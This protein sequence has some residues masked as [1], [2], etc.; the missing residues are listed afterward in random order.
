MRERI[1]DLRATERHSPN[2]DYVVDPPDELRIEFLADEDRYLNRDVTVRQDGCIT[3]L[4]LDDVQVDG[5][6]PMSIA[7]KLEERYSEFIKEPRILVT[8]TAYRSKRIF[9]TGEVGRQGSIP[10]TGQQTVA[11]ALGEV[12]GLTRRAWLAHAKVIRGDV[13]DPEIYAIDLNELLFAGDM[14]QNIM[15][16][17]DDHLRVPPNPFAW[18]GYQLDN[19]LYPFR[20]ILSTFST[21]EGLTRAGERTF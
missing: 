16:A 3:L 18:A 7:D 12:G 2:A 9:V 10:Y 20:S 14:K 13:D 19:L 4:L 21:G 17:E 6:T 11:D 5:M 15:L 1:L 8:V